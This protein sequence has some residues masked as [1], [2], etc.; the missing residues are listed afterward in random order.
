ML[1]VS[2]ER[3]AVVQQLNLRPCGSR[4][5]DCLKAYSFHRCCGSDGRYLRSF[6]ERITLAN[7]VVS[8]SLA[9][10]YSHYSCYYQVV[11][12]KAKL[13][14]EPANRGQQRQQHRWQRQD[15]S[16]CR[17]S[18]DSSEKHRCI[19]G[20]HSKRTAAWISRRL[21]KMGRNR[22]TDNLM[23]NK[24]VDGTSVCIERCP[25]AQRQ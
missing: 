7:A 23:R 6:V 4:F 12:R 13:R 15:I 9:S 8:V 20:L 14:G 19:G 10:V 11:G 2:A 16:L 3:V 18:K 5:Q 25:N 24:T 21:P 22:S 1:L 17:T